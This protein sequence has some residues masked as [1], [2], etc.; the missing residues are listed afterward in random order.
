MFLWPFLVCIQQRYVG[1][2][3]EEEGRRKRKGR[4]DEG[5]GERGG[6]VEEGGRKKLGLGLNFP[7]RIITVE[8]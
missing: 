3:R 1:E 4:E 7:D 2:A 8:F 6:G 5:R